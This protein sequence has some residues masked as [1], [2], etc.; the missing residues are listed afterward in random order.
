MILGKTPFQIGGLLRVSQFSADFSFQDDYGR[1][2]FLNYLKFSRHAYITYHIKVEFEF[3][4]E[5]L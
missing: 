4:L 2:D 3:E 1:I 5:P